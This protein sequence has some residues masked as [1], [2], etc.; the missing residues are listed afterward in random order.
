[1]LFYELHE[2]I[3]TRK[4]V[5][6]VTE[7]C[8]KKGV[9]CLTFN[10]P[11]S[12]LN[13]DILAQAG[14][15]SIDPFSCLANSLSNQ[16]RAIAR[17]R[18]FS[19]KLLC[20]KLRVCAGFRFVFRSARKSSC[21]C[22]MFHCFILE[23]VVRESLRHQY[24]AQSRWNFVSSLF[25][26]IC[27][28]PHFWSTFASNWSNTVDLALS[29]GVTRAFHATTQKIPLCASASDTYGNPGTLLE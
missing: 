16:Q 23:K 17:E 26:E 15:E 25:N 18:L 4:G 11:S 20:S 28:A 10:S 12:H 5:G 14:K 7:K 22:T 27:G 2:Q 19:L 13:W 9:L 21:D 3:W 1:M 6:P 29:A 8:L 24:N